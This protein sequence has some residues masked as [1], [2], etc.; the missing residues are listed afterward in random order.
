MKN[1]KRDIKVE[2]RKMIIIEKLYLLRNTKK[3]K[4]GKKRSFIQSF[5]G[6]TDINNPFGD[7]DLLSRLWH[8]KIQKIC[9]KGLEPFLNIQSLILKLRG[10]KK[11]LY[12]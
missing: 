8:K 5:Y 4:A 12:K 2:I 9:S 1:Q 11:D 10:T 7:P 6:Y 3:K